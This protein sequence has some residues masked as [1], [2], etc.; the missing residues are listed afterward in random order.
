[1]LVQT[2]T[3]SLVRVR[4]YRSVTLRHLRHPL[5]P[6]APNSASNAASR[7][8]AS[9]C[10][11]FTVPF[12]EGFPN[13]PRLREVLIEW[14]GWSPERIVDELSRNIDKP[15]PGY[16]AFEKLDNALFRFPKPRVTFVVVD[17][18]D[19]RMLSFWAHEL[20]MRLP[21]LLAHGGVVTVECK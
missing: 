12:L 18:A 15:H 19:A 7:P 8:F 21:R 16:Q 5:R 10:V 1:M 20:E 14:R 9:P 2:Y 3:H 6:S 17:P 4:V 11:I 13:T